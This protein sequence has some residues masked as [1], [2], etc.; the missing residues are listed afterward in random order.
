MSKNAT[1][2]GFRLALWCS[3]IDWIEIKLCPIL[4]FF[5]KAFAAA[6]GQWGIEASHDMIWNRV[7]I[8]FGLNPVKE[9]HDHQGHSYGPNIFW[10]R[11]IRLFGISVVVPRFSFSGSS[12]ANNSQMLNRCARCI[13]GSCFSSLMV[14]SRGN[15][16]FGNFFVIIYFISWNWTF[17]N[18]QYWFCITSRRFSFKWIQC[19]SNWSLSSILSST[20][21]GFYNLGFWN[22]F[23]GVLEKVTYVAVKGKRNA[24][25]FTWS[26]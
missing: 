11:S 23:Q 2:S 24:F 9:P 4:S 21:P 10:Q 22:Q 8:W 7:I 16:T 25:V 19:C 5:L 1:D 26:L 17:Q 3:T 12:A 13:E 14:Y 18:L 6:V 15:A 20:K